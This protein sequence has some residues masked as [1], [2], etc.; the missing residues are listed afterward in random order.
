[1]TK[2]EDAP[3]ND[4]EGDKPSQRRKKKIKN[5]TIMRKNLSFN[6]FVML[7]T[8]AVAMLMASCIHD[9]VV[10]I[11]DPI[12]DSRN[13][14]FSANVVDDE[15]ATRGGASRRTLSDGVIANADGDL[16]LP[17]VVT[18][19][20]GIRT[21]APVADTRGAK[22][23]KDDV[24]RM[25]VWATYDDG[26]G[27]RLFFA[28]ENHDGSQGLDFVR[29]EGSSVFHSDPQYMWPGSGT[30]DF[31]SVGNLPSDIASSI[32]ETNPGS[33]A[34]Y[35][36][37]NAE[38]TAPEKFTYRV[39]DAAERQSDII[40]AKATEIQGDTN[41][42]VSLDFKHIM[43]A[44]NFKVGDVVAGTIKSISLTGVYNKGEYLLSDNEWV[45]RYIE[46]GG[47]FN[48]NI[49]GD[50]VV[51]EDDALN[52]TQL[53]SDGAT[54]MMIPQSLFSGAELVV[55]FVHANG[56][57]Y[58][59]RASIQGN[60]WA[61]GTTTNYLINIDHNYELQIV[62]LDNVL[63]SHYIITKVEISSEYPIWELT[64]VADDNADVSIQLEQ[65]VNSLAKQG[66]WTD[67]KADKDSNGNIYVP[68]NAESARGVPGSP[69]YGQATTSQVVYVFIPENISDNTRTITLT[70]TGYRTEGPAGEP[71]VL[72]LT[73]K[74]VQWYNPTGTAGPSSMG[75]EVLIEN[76]QID[77]GFCW[78]GLSATF[79]L[80]Q[81]GAS[82]NPET[83]E[84]GTGNIPA[85]QR[86]KIIPAMELAGIDVSKI[87]DKIYAG[88]NKNDKEVDNPDWDPNYYIQVASSGH[89]TYFINVDLSKIGNIEIAQDY[90][91]GWQNTND[92]YHFEGINALNQ[93]IEFCKTWT[94]ITNPDGRAGMLQDSL[95]YAAFY[96]MKRN[97]FHYYEEGLEVG[98]MVVPHIEEKDIV[99]YLP[100]KEQ[101][102]DIIELNSNWGQQ[103]TFNDY[104]WTSTAYLVDDGDK[105]K[106]YSYINGVETISYRTEKYLTMA[107]RKWFE[108]DDVEMGGNVVTPGTGGENG[109][110]GSGGNGGGDTGQNPGTGIQ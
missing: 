83:D 17:L 77:W 39:P 91:N 36:T 12:D 29:Q 8:A 53:N 87:C 60:N 38:G 97:R 69:V 78:D 98:T 31:V 62:P 23:T 41:A 48:A 4:V 61:M 40:I 82:Y 84:Y 42:S 86:K 11:P 7:A 96:A 105:S 2:E 46:D 75:L 25:R 43:A 99:W 24:F 45:N 5:V 27:E 59:L 90:D 81:G 33:G 6:H 15:A 110:S 63:D 50:R 100:A 44:V 80:N 85:G 18:Q 13:I 16:S 58:T 35:A 51:V 108:T 93:L 102:K 30:F 32:S 103:Y 68:T 76:G 22:V 64:A 34:F 55:E 26:K 72:N 67:K 37:L 52:G 14:G 106:S 88:G 21:S 66:F 47:V 107:V 3:R 57:T 95:D 56:K 1:M 94:D 74:P 70:L 101:F 20:Q 92:L 104:Y 89:H 71:K 10:L 65:E 19:E 79:I 49:G 73:Q 54:F 109:S 9:E 28:D